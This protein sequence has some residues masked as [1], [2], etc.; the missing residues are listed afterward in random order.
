MQV[1]EAYPHLVQHNL[2]T[3]V[4][5]VILAVLA[6]AE[7]GLPR[8][9]LRSRLRTAALWLR[10]QRCN[11]PALAVQHWSLSEAPQSRRFRRFVT[12]PPAF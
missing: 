9:A 3:R 5:K 4:G 6:A 2:S 7:A 8:L 11:R 10:E 1:S 12:P